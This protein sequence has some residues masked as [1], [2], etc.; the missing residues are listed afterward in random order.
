MEGI[1]HAVTEHPLIA[2]AVCFAVLLILYFLFKS[3]IKLALILIIVAL[4]I[5][6]WFY[7]QHPESRPASLKDA[8]QKVRTGTEKAVDRGKEA[9]KQ[10]KE[11]FDKRKEA[12]EKG[13]E[14]VDQGK[15]V[16]DKG[17]DKGK[18][19][20]DTGKNIAGDI[21]R[22]LEGKKETGGRH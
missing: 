1:V 5:A 4:A 14:W 6:G 8:L 13:R 7:F 11:L 21:G 16:L 9:Y 19:A 18:D 3:L 17:I 20:L 2:M 15:T 22:L 12:Y 10:G